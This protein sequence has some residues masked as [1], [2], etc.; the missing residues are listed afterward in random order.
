MGFMCDL[1]E[2]AYHKGI[3]LLVINDIGKGKGKDS[4]CGRTQ[5]Q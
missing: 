1:V 2:E 4:S 3:C 5:E